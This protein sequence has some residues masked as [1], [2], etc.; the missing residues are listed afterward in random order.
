M[1]RF[2]CSDPQNARV[3]IATCAQ[4]AGEEEEDLRVLEALHRRGI[5]A[6]HAIWDDPGVD[7]SSFALVVIRGL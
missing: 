3:A 6:V 1:S 4:V 7:W 5:T 2:H